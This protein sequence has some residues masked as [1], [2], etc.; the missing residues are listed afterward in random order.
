MVANE[1]AILDRVNA[2]NWAV[3]YRCRW[4][5]PDAEHVVPQL[6]K[7]LES[8][9][10]QVIDEAL[11]ALFRIGAPAVSVAP[12][13]AK[14]TRS[15]HPMTKQ[16]AVLTLG[17]IAHELPAVCV[18]PLALTLDDPLCCRDALRSLA[19][20]GPNAIDALEYVLP[21]FTNSDAKV[22][23]SVVETASAIDAEQPEVAEMILKATTD[24]SKIVRE[25]AS[26]C[27]RKVKNG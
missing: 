27:L 15:Q 20:I 21:L 7:L 12:E 2:D 26:K 17:Q 11:C 8:E 19:F 4:S 16:L 13:V 23:K 5:K 9:H 10:R 22:R 3:L 6:A 24:R 14:L 18:E 25:A 1:Q